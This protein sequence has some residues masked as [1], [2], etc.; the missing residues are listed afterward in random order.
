MSKPESVTWGVIAIA[1]FIAHLMWHVG[2]GD[3]WNAMWACHVASTFIGLGG[4]ARN[5]TMVVI[6]L[7]LLAI[8]IPLWGIFLFGG[9]TLVPTSILTHFGAAA[10]GLILIRKPPFQMQPRANL[11]SR[12]WWRAFVALAILVLMTRLLTDRADNINL[13]FDIH[14][15]ENTLPLDHALYVSAMAMTVVFVFIVSEWLLRKLCGAND[16]L[17]SD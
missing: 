1:F 3:P 10:V 7:L 11:L 13:A 2:S 5:R 12:I 14:G 4:I 17:L 9:G 15:R 8:G 6:G 16:A